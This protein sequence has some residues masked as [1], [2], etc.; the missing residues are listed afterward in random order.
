MG[1]CDNRKEVDCTQ[2]EILMFHCSP[3]LRIVLMVQLIVCTVWGLNKE[4]LLT[5]ELMKV[6]PKRPQC[7]HCGFPQS[8]YLCQSLPLASS[9]LSG[10]RGHPFSGSLRRENRSRPDVAESPEHHVDPPWDWTSEWLWQVPVYYPPSLQNCDTGQQQPERA[11]PP[12]LPSHASVEAIWTDCIRWGEANPCRHA[13]LY[14]CASKNTSTHK[15]KHPKSRRVGEFWLV[16]GRHDKRHAKEG[17]ALVCLMCIILAG[18]RWR[19]PRTDRE[20]RRRRLSR[21]FSDPAAGG[22]P[23]T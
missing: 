8:R 4:R 20:H 18:L 9:Y 6:P 15:S 2:Q 17:E 23:L 12:S 13:C 10:C 22:S 14:P 3:W 5:A 21:R 1:S 11:E 16:N 19:L 7:A